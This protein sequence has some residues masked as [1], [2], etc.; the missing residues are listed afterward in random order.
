VYWS[1]ELDADL[2]VRGRARLTARVSSDSDSVHLNVYLYDADRW[3]NGVLLTH[4]TASA[5]DLS[6]D[7]AHV[8]D[9]DLNAVAHDIPAGHRVA[10]AIDTLDPQYSTL[11]PLGTPIAL[12]HETAEPMT[13]DIDVLQP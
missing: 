3:G 7:G 1:D 8:L 2:A 9:I 5:H 11:V 13:L 4:G 6:G 10:I 12:H